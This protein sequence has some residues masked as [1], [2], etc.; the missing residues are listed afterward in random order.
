[1]RRMQVMSQHGF[2]YR[3]TGSEVERL[4]FRRQE[5]VPHLHCVCFSPYAEV[6]F[7]IY[8]FESVPEYSIFSS[9]ATLSI[10]LFFCVPWI[11]C[12]TTF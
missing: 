6:F 7:V 4:A 11:G 8:V 3:K 2:A 10:S 1:M 12:G 5:V 9:R